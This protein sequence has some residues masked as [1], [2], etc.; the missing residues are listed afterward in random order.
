MNWREEKGG[1]YN[2]KKQNILLNKFVDSEPLNDSQN[3]MTQQDVENEDIGGQTPDAQFT[4]SGIRRQGQHY[5]NQQIFQNYQHDYCS[6]AFACCLLTQCQLSH[7]VCFSSVVF[8][9]GLLI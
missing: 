7:V 5:I 1:K 3:T 2:F 4:L 6:G 8:R 9:S